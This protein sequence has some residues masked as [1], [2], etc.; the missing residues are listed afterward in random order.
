MPRQRKTVDVWRIFVDYGDGF[1]KEPECEEFGYYQYRVN[2]LAYQ[3]NCNHPIRTNKGRIRKDALPGGWNEKDN[4][5]QEAKAEIEWI[6]E[7]DRLNG[8]AV[9]RSRRLE[10]AKARLNRLRKG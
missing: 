7:M 8:K 1:G 4:A 10:L 5:I 6:N 3:R 2:K 9:N